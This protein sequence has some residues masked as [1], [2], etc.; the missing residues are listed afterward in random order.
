MQSNAFLRIMSVLVISAL[1]ALVAPTIASAQ[2]IVT[3]AVTGTVTDPTGAAVAGAHVDLKSLSTDVELT[4]NTNEAGLYQFPLLKPGNYSLTIEQQGFK[5]LSQSVLVL[6]GQTTAVDVKLEL[7]AA[8]STIEVTAAVPVLQTEDANITSNFGTQAIQDVPNPGNDLTYVAQTAPGISMNT[9]TG[10]G[11]GNFSA[12]GLPGTANLFTINGNDYNDP[13]LNLNNSGSSNL[14]LGAND[15]QEVAVV[16]NGYTGQYGR[17]AGAQIDYSTKSGSNSFHGNL[18]YN[19]TGRYLNANDALLNIAGAPRPFMN[20]NQW[21]ASLGGPIVKNKAFFY[22]D[23]EAVQYIFGSVSTTFTPTPAFESY[24][25]GN[26]PKD[27]ATQAFYQNVFNLYNAAPGIR[28]AAAVPGSCDTSLPS[29]PSAGGLSTECLQSWKTSLSNGNKEYLIIGRVDYDISANDKI[30]GQAKFDRGLQPTYTDPINA[31]FNIQS[32]QPEDDGQLNWTHIFTPTVVNNFVGSVLYYSAIFASADISKDLGIFP[33]ILFIPDSSL[34]PLGVDS[35]YGLGFASNFYS[36][37]G[38]N[39]TQ[40]QLVDDLSITRGAHSFKMGINFRRNDITD[41]TAAELTQ[42]PAIETTML[43]FAN[44]QISVPGGPTGSVLQNFALTPKQPN[45]FSSWGIYFQD[46]FKVNRKLTLTMAIRADRNN[47]GVCQ[48]SCG[49]LPVSPFT[50]LQHGAAIPYNAAYG[51]SFY[52]GTKQ[53]FPAVEDIVIEPRFGFAWTPVGQN[54]VLRGGIGLFPDLYPG[55]LLDFFTTNFP[56]VD[57][58]NISPPTA[59]VPATVAFD[60][61]PAA[62]TAFPNSGA[63]FVASCNSSFQKNFFTPGG[64]LLTYTAAAPLCATSVPNY[65]DVVSKV[66]NPKYV[67]WNFEIQHSFG[68]NL[69]VSANYVGNHG[70]DIFLFNPYVNAFCDANCTA[71]GLTDT[72]LPAVAPDPRVGS[73][74]L[75]TNN[76]RENYNGVTFSIQQNNWKGLSWHLNY[77]YSHE[78]DDISNGGVANEPYSVFNSITR[79]I[80]P[81]NPNLGYGSGDYDSRNVLSGAYVY[82]LPFKSESRL[83]NALVGGWQVSGTIFYHSSFPFSVIDQGVSIPLGTTNNMAN[84]TILLQPAPGFTQ[85]SFSNGLSCVTTPCFTAAD[86]ASPTNFTGSVVGRNAFR[87]PG[88]FGGDASIRKSFN[89]TERVSFQLGLNAFNVFNHAN[90]G[91]PWNSTS[92]FPLGSPIVM[93]QPP[94]SPY[95]AFAAAATDMRMAQ[96]VGK[97]IF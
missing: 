21:G 43:G 3:G 83:R 20:N 68:N 39:V 45:A 1:A 6:L 62:T 81:F 13:F 69:L 40:W 9:T 44:D 93:Q 50:D 46:G 5:K 60:N 53:I 37:Q 73:V 56:Q 14:L 71:A 70:Y 96:I 86:F 57:V 18:L 11:F 58:W 72:G 12:F 41:F 78:L 88:F 38:R 17:Q 75:M 32:H 91:T 59:P 4:T 10:G 16:S 48:K 61:N 54:T 8:T 84:A 35:G 97:L 87:G 25:L 89:I 47:S 66:L 30:F 27:A 31:S 90:F 63:V 28:N 94:T 24:V 49:T 15:V 64:N 80:N 52:A 7:G 34:S 67:Q 82:Q 19:W 36:P 2:T 26:I 55:G 29:F 65:N 95:G 42:F 85:R 22:V 74:Q 23:Y 33:G 79:Q 76:G 77:T 51:G 92:G